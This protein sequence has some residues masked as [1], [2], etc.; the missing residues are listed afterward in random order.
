MNSDP[1]RALRM[2]PSNPPIYVE[3]DHFVRKM[4]GATQAHLIE[5]AGGAFYV[6]KF[7]NNPQHPRVVINEWITSMILRHLGIST[8]TTAIVNISTDFIRDNPEV[9]M[10]HHSGCQVLPT[11]G[12]HFGSRFP[13]SGAVYDLLPNT[14]LG[15]VANL[16]DFCGVLVADKWLGNTDYR[17]SIFIKILCVNSPL[18]FVAQMIDN[19]QMF[20]GGSWRFQDS[21]LQGPYFG[22]VYRH[23]RGLE[24]FEPWLTAV[25]NFPAAVV[26]DAFHQMPCSWRSVDTEAAFGALLDQLMRRRERVDDLIRACRAQPSNPFPSWS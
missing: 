11:S 26:E 24:A 20:G 1:I 18:S 19:G 6:V 8:P 21:P 16:S 25:A 13:S 3:A 17:Q 7:T 23:V 4:R 5:T 12:F 9:R 14:L 15:S 2:M 22:K 10:Q